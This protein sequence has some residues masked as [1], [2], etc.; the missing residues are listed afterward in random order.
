MIPA[1]TCPVSPADVIV[2]LA[3]IAAIRESLT[4]VFP[5]CFAFRDR[6]C[7]RLRRARVAAD[8]TLIFRRP[9]EFS[10]HSPDVAIV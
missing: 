2:D 5:S 9:N 3:R 10:T 4:S 6:V 7:R 8:F 1:L